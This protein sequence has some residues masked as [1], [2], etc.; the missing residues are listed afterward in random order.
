M[1]DIKTPKDHITLVPIDFSESSKN[2]MIYAVEMAK[3]FDD[4]ITL[5]NV[6]SNGM[7]SLFMN[8]SQK[9]LL[10]EGINVRL[11]QYKADIL[12]K[13]PAAKVNTRIEEGK[14]YKAIT[15][16]AEA[17]NCDTIVM[18]TNGANGIEQFMGSTTSR[19]I[20]VAPCPV[21]AVKDDHG[22]VTFDN[23]V[24]PIDLTKSSKQK[25]DWAIRI[26]R[27]FNSTVHIIMELDEDEFIKHKIEGNL[28]QVENA[29]KD[30]NIKYVSKL[31]DDRKYPDNI[32]MDTIQ[33]ADEVEADLIIIMTQSEGGFAEL[34]VGSYAEQVV[35]SSQKT[36]VMCINPKQTYSYVGLEL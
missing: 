4:E 28:R 25:V 21:I 13:W 27:R 30:N 20:N 35:N 34:F 8:D 2:A 5:L 19:V 23:I 26:A 1:T 22:K 16:V 12:A 36:P 15:K 6:I 9:D 24:L 31:L 10:R 17:I 11:N 18:G 32:G 7:K 29:M 33:Y 14:P 3:I